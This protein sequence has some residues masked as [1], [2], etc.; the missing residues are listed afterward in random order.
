MEWRE[1]ESDSMPKIYSV[2]IGWILLIGISLVIG[3]VVN[4]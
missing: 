1:N 3:V 4:M 2:I